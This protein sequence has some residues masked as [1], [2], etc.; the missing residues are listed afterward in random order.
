V[1]ISENEVTMVIMDGRPRHA[2]RRG[3]VELARQQWLWFGSVVILGV[4]SGIVLA[5]GTS[6][7]AGSTALGITAVAAALILG[8]G[9]HRHHLGGD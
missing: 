3:T 8:F 9:R 5:V 4:A 1:S 6:M 7:V 2:L